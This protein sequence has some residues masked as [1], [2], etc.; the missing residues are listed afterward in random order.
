[1]QVGATQ[2]DQEQVKF[3]SAEKAGLK[4]GCFDNLSHLI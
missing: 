4:V 2:R 3:V 1:M